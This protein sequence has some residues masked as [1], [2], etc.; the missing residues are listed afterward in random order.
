MNLACAATPLVLLCPAWKHWG[1]S[2]TVK[3]GTI[4][5]HSRMDEVIPFADSEE[6]ICASGLPALALV[7]TGANH[8]LADPASLAAMLRACEK[9]SREKNERDDIGVKCGGDEEEIAAY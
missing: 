1:S 9:S 2:A 6:L 7:E 4:V 8:R 3:S 5:L